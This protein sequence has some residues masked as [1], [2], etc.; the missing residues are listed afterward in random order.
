MKIHGTMK[1]TIR[2]QWVLLDYVN[3]VIHIMQPETR[4]FYK[5]EEMWSDAV[6]RNY[7]RNNVKYLNNRT[8]FHNN[9]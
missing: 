3:V 6:E 4:K 9:H 7:T 8:F 1:D 2:L 5:L